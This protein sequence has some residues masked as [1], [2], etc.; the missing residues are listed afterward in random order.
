MLANRTLAMHMIVLGLLFCP[1]AASLLLAQQSTTGPKP[2]AGIDRGLRPPNRSQVVISGVPAYL[3]RHGCGPTAAGM[4]IGFWDG[5]SFP[6]LVSGPAATQTAEVNAMIADDH[7]FE[8][9]DNAFADHYRDYSCP[10]D[11]SPGP[12]LP[13]KSETGGAHADNCLADFMLTSRSANSN[14]YGWSWFNHVEVALEAYFA[15]QLPGQAVQLQSIY[16]NDFSWA[17]YK[18]EIDNRRPMVL[19]VDTDADGWT[20]HFVTAIGYDEAAHEY[21]VL[22]TWDQGVHWYQWRP[23]A[24]GWDWG[25]YGVTTF[26]PSYVCVDSDGD[27]FGDP[28]HPENQCPVDNCPAVSNFDQRDVDHDGLGDLCDP[29]ADNDGLPNGF[30]NCPYLAN[31]AQSDADVDS[32]GDDCDNCPAT[33]NPDQRD[34]NSDGVGDLCDGRVHIYTKSLPD[35]YLSAPYYMQLEGAGGTLPLNWIFFGG[36][37]P[38][39][40]SFQEGVGIISGTPTYKAT[41]YFTLV[42]RD[43]SVPAKSCTLSTSILITDPPC[44]CGDADGS[45]AI[46]ISDAVYLINFIFA[47][48]PAPNPML[49][50]DADCSNAISI[51]DAVYLINYIFAGGPAPCA[52]CP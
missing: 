44:P 39:G 3:W 7:D 28:G 33:F 43:S 42:L 52:A 41:F 49:S 45:S 47:G 6:D 13:D 31:P 5:N 24:G 18:A 51:S 1:G 20:D 9:C 8:Y 40:L 22:D 30:D 12:L 21:G 48:G 2:P 17:Q 16:F 35:G 50:G 27:H 11:A 46:S 15:M 14:Y 37:L 25:V 38:Y 23:V 34:E 29:D 26:N 19:L 32:V 4:V 36:D 10:I